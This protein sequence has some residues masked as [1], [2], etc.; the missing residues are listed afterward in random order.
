MKIRQNFQRL[1]ELAL[2]LP[3]EIRGGLL[4]EPLFSNDHELLRD[5]YAAIMHGHVEKIAQVTALLASRLRDSEQRRP[6]DEWVLRL[7]HDYPNGDAGLFSFYLLNFGRLKPGEAVFVGPGVPHAYLSGD[8]VECMASS[9][10]VV[11]AGLTPKFKDVDTLLKMLH[12]QSAVFEILHPR[13]HAGGPERYP[14]PVKEFFVECVELSA[15]RSFASGGGS[16]ELV[17]CLEGQGHLSHGEQR[18]QFASGESYLIPAAAGSVDINLESGKLF[19][20]GVP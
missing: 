18:Y 1:P 5:V 9:D 13:S 15:P 7:L 19:R 8:L 14:A 3:D 6:E 4:N 11:R 2:L 17:F 10:N 16:V 12:F 20:V